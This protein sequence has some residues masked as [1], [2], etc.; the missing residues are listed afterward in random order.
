MEGTIQHGA[1]SGR[2]AVEFP[3][4]LQVGGMEIGVDHAGAAQVHGSHNALYIFKRHL[5]KFFF[6]CKSSRSLSK[7]MKLPP[8]RALDSALRG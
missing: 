4:L 1:H 7:A 5:V 2:I 3:H 6:V 8:F